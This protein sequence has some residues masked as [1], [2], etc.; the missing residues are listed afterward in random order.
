M[1]ESTIEKKVTAYAFVKGW[2]SIKLNGP[3]DRGK[4]DRVFLKR[5]RAVFVEFKAPGRK[6]C[7]L[8]KHFASKLKSNGFDTHIVDNVKDGVALVD[9]NFLPE[10]P[11]ITAKE[12]RS[13][14]K[15]QGW[16]ARQLG[17]KLKYTRSYC[18]VVETDNQPPSWAFYNKLTALPE[19]QEWAAEQK[20]STHA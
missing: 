18:L 4:P 17:E 8:Q 10:P 3:G 2:E 11:P 19:W 1:K 16:D 13:F 15:A 14:R 9:R 12:I 20:E 5:G 7:E 6:P